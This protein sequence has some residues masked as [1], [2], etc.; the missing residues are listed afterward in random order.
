VP[1]LVVWCGALGRAIPSG[2]GYL[3]TY[4]LAAV[5]VAEAIGLPT[6]EAFAA[7]LLVHASIIVFTSLG[8][9]ISLASLGWGRTARAADIGEAG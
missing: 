3:G 2:P 1:A 5:K 4:E 6:D 8:G 9:L 7:A